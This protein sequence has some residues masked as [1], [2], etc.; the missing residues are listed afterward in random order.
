M[1]IIAIP[2]ALLAPVPL[3]VYT[4]LKI[5]ETTTQDGEL[6]SV[7]LGLNSSTVE[8]FQE[9]SRDR[10][11]EDLMK[12]TSDFKRFGEGS[13]EDWYAKERYPITLLNVEGKLAAIV[14]FGP[15]AFPDLVEGSAPE[16]KGSWHTFAIRTYHPFRGKRLAS[17]F[18][19]FAIDFYRKLFPG[20]GIWLD[21]GAENEGAV[22]LYKK[23]GFLHDGVNSEGRLV[24]SQTS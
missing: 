21:V 11:D 15:K 2:H 24:M 5:G 4:S 7:H 19:S 20:S 18:A 14:W 6:F 13:Y 22:A 8:A 9:R 10:S 17:P 1:D 12:F 23:L 16:V 3:P